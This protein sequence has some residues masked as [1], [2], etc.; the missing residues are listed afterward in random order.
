MLHGCRSVLIVKYLVYSKKDRNFSSFLQQLKN[1]MYNVKTLSKRKLKWK[2]RLNLYDFYAKGC[3]CDI[4][5]K[6]KRNINLIYCV[7]Q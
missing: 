6:T 3:S 1:L 5:K 4:M 2:L 7:N